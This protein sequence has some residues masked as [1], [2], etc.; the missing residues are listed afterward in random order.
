MIL[1]HENPL[2]MT[3]VCLLTQ[4]IESGTQRIICLTLNTF[5]KDQS[6]PTNYLPKQLVLQVVQIKSIWKMLAI[7]KLF[8]LYVLSEKIKVYKPIVDEKMRVRGNDR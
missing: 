5:W 3:R 4:T 8:Q 6:K 7:W 2:V 1:M